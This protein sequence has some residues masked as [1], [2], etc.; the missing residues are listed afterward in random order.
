MKVVKLLERQEVIRLF[1][2]GL[3]VAP[4]ANSFLAYLALPAHFGRGFAV[5]F[6]VFRSGSWLQIVLDISSVLIGILLLSGKQTGWKL[7]LVLIGGY[8]CTQLAHLG[9]SLR[10]NPL[11]G[12]FFVANVALFLFI[13]DQLVFKQSKEKETMLHETSSRPSPSIDQRNQNPNIDPKPDLGRPR[14]PGVTES[15]MRPRRKP[16]AVLKKN[17]LRSQTQILVNFHGIG[18]WAQVVGISDNGIEM[19]S[20]GPVPLQIDSRE[21]ELNLTPQLVVRARLKSR[22]GAYYFFE[23]IN[24]TEKNIP[25]LNQWLIAQAS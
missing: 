12:L 23:Y 6:S 20:S 5:Y 7:M 3:V 18:S 14:S 22:R 16:N 25:L 10:A 17:V 1:G 24:L 19:K 9:E 4:L 8:M 2:L 21:V 11:N 15:A 13:G